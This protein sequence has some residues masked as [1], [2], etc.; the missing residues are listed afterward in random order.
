MNRTLTL[1]LIVTLAS[2]LGCGR[3]PMGQS[4]VNT[5]SAHAFVGDQ[6]ARVMMSESGD[7]TPGQPLGLE[8]DFAESQSEESR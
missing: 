3:E 2:V 8:F 7:G 6:V 1:A 5:T 4:D